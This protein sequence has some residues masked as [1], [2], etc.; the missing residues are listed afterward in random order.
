MFNS[1]EENRKIII[2]IRA[3]VNEEDNDDDFD[4]EMDDYC[5]FMKQMFL[6]TSGLN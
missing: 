2:E 1:D 3:L 4:E 6:D 5:M